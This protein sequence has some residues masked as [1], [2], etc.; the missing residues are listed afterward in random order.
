MDSRGRKPVNRYLA[1]LDRQGM[2]I[3]LVWQRGRFN[4]TLSNGQTVNLKGHVSPPFGAYRG[5]INGQKARA[6]L[7]YTLV[8]LCP[9]DAPW[10]PSGPTNSASC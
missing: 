7:K 1:Y 4:V 5:G 10:L 6:W 2:P 9:R 8:Y 3:P